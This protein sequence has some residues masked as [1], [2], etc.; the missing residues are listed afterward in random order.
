MTFLEKTLFTFYNIITRFI[1]NDFEINRNENTMSKKSTEM[2]ITEKPKP[3]RSNFG[4][5]H[6]Y[7]SAAKYSNPDNPIWQHSVQTSGNLSFS[8]TLKMYKFLRKTYK[9]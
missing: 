3:F 1:I 7:S 9:L 4:F 8:S 5:E 2:K 6:L